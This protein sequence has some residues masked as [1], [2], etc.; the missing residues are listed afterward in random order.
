MKI[1]QGRD[2]K[3]MLLLFLVCIILAKTVWMP[4][5]RQIDA[6]T[7]QM[8][9]TEHILVTRSSG[10][11]NL[12]GSFDER[13]QVL[14][15]EWSKFQNVVYRVSSTMTGGTAL[16]KNIQSIALTTGTQVLSASLLLDERNGDLVNIAVEIKAT[17][18]ID[19]LFDFL[20]TITLIR[21][22]HVIDRLRLDNH[23]QVHME[24]VLR[25][26]LL[27]S[28]DAHMDVNDY[29]IDTHSRGERARFAMFGSA[30]LESHVA[31]LPTSTEDGC[32]EYESSWQIAGMVYG[33]Q[34]A[35]AVLRHKGSG[36]QEVVQVGDFLEDEQVVTIG[37]GHVVL[38]KSTAVARLEITR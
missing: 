20:S 28:G 12:I 35:T 25:S 9:Q 21:P 5:Y 24:V 18:E 6:L 15:L 31:I 10:L 8:K 4:L 36:R 16:L 14:N 26:L 30:P 29:Q 33:V 13:D 1:L 3:K 38:E 22:V 19:E 11:S 34:G 37:T 27:I 32:Q 23:G 7:E 2:Q 17:G